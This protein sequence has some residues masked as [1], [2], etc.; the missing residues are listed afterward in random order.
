MSTAAPDFQDEVVHTGG[1]IGTVIA[2]Y[3]RN[4]IPCLDVRGLEDRIYYGTPAAN[5]TVIR[6]REEIEGTSE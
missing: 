1:T 3:E 2:T 4:G 6:T 5:W